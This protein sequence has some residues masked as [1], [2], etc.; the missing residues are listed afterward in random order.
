MPLPNPYTLQGFVT[1]ITIFLKKALKLI[2][3]QSNTKK[4]PYLSI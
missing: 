2:G 1:S 4:F 3:L